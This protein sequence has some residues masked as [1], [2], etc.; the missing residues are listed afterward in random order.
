[1]LDKKYAETVGS[2]DQVLKKQPIGVQLATDGWK[3]KNVNEG[4][5]IQNFI[6]N[7]PDGGSSF[8]SAHNTD[9]ACMDNV[10]Y[11]RI[12]TEQIV[13]LGERLGSI[14][15]VLGCITDREAAVQLAFN[16]L[17][18]KYHWLVNLVCQVSRFCS[19]SIK[20]T[21]ATALLGVGSWL[22]P[23]HQGFAE[24]VHLL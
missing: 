11:E 10:E 1:M 24:G 21:A 19:C 14:E 3:R 15:K 9:G 22:Q 16:R 20:R 7:F 23:P 5:K 6:A 12:L 13:A 4:Q 2:V 18:D 8:L 17:E